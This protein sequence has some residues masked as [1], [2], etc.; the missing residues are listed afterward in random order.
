[1]NIVTECSNRS[2]NRLSYWKAAHVQLHAVFHTLLFGLEN[3]FGI[4]NESFISDY[5]SI[6]LF[7]FVQLVG[8]KVENILLIYGLSM[9]GAS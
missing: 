6:N 9:F 1:M 3:G 8:W 2:L 4:E 7:A 5:I